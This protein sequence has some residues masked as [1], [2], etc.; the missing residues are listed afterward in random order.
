M[1]KVKRDF[2]ERVDEINKYFDLLVNIIEKEAWLLIPN[3]TGDKKE[4]FD[5]DLQK[6]LK[7]SAILL[8]YNVIESTVAN[9]LDAIHDAFSSENLKFSELSEKIQN[10]FIQFYYKN[11][12]DGKLKDENIIQH[13][14]IMIDTWS[15]EKPIQLTYN[16]YTKYKTGSQFAGNLEAKE[17]KKLANKYGVQFDKEISEL[18]SIKN[19]RNKLAH[20]E[21]S[22]ANCCNSDTINYIKV[23]KDKSLDYLSEFINAVDIFVTNRKYAK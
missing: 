11:L 12:K 22:F 13:I 15:Y 16:E 18:A 5:S 19:K 10:I 7:S 8:L 23:L 17:I 3:D 20:G 2:N 21:L 14:K 4:K 1:L 6:T 9:C